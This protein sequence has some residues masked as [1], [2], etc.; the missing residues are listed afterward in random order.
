MSRSL[1]GFPFLNYSL[2]ELTVAVI[3]HPQT[4]ENHYRDYVSQI[5]DNVSGLPAGVFE[6]SLLQRF[7][8]RSHDRL[9]SDFH[10]LFVVIAVFRDFFILDPFPGRGL[11]VS[12]LSGRALRLF[13]VDVALSSGGPAGVDGLINYETIAKIFMINRNEAF[14]EYEMFCIM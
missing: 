11:L 10:F 2:P 1:I 6:F 8:P 3:Y 12:L 9:P 5:R 14:A 13:C 7:L 4:F